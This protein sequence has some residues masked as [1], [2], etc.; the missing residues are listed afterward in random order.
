MDEILVDN[1]TKAK[2]ISKPYD[3]T[4]FQLFNEKMCKKLINNFYQINEYLNSCENLSQSR[5]MINIE[6]DTVSG[7]NYSKY[8]F[9]KNIQPLNSVLK[10]YS[11]KLIR[12]QY[13]K[14]HTS[15]K[16][17]LKYTIQLIHDKK[18]YSI[19]P[20]TDSPLRSVTQITYLVPEEEKGKNL[21]V[22][23]YNDCINVSRDKWEELRPSPHYKFDNF[24]KVKQVEYYP[25]SSI[26][27]KVCQKSYHGV[28]E[29][30]EKCN[31][32]SIQTIVWKNE[33][34]LNEREKRIRNK[35][36]RAKKIL[37]D[38]EKKNV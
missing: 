21:G 22:C 38:R 4:T 33:K 37:E 8:P 28:E 27:F 3:H 15:I 16:K 31:R 30:H 23:L 10:M 32:M 6:G 34:T 11:D 26:N 9:L 20:H 13:E 29:I 24:E 7:I 35:K 36:E 12:L 19:G 2:I 5:F 1:L 25:G 14:Y 17:K 18:S